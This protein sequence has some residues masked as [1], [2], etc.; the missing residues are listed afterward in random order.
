[1]QVKIRPAVEGD[2]ERLLEL[3][4][5]ISELHYNNRP[6]IFQAR[7]KKYELEQVREILNS[8]DKP[9]LAAVNPDGV[10]IGYA[11]CQ[12]IDNTSRPLFNNFKSLYIDDI[13]VDER[14]RNQGTGTLL[15]EK[16]KE[17][18]KEHGCYCIDLNVWQFNQSAVKF[19]EKCGFDTRSVKMEYIL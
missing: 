5:Q 1:M 8:P 12:I 19:Y 15:L 4:A 11:F 14:F 3:L 17:L 2:Y 16:C 18:A 6:D 9:V 13:C 7:V 10:L